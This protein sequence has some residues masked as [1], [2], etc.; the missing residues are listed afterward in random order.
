MNRENVMEI[1][2][3]RNEKRKETEREECKRQ[4]KP[5]ET[6]RLHHF[7][8]CQ[9]KCHFFVTLLHQHYTSMC[10]YFNPFKCPINVHVVSEFR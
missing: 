4:K 6:Y 2:V 5:C 1:S 10:I 3:D 9:K 8:L 7:F